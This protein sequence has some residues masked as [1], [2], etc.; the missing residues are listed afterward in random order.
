M[1]TKKS[2]NKTSVSQVTG[3]L[4]D[5]SEVCDDGNAKTSQQWTKSEEEAGYKKV[6]DISNEILN[7]G[8]LGDNSK[9]GMDALSFPN[10]VP[11]GFIRKIWKVMQKKVFSVN[12]VS[13]RENNDN[14]VASNTNFSCYH[15]DESF[16]SDLERAK[17]I[18]DDH[19]GKLCY[20]TPEDF[21]DRLKPNKR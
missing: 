11:K 19:P 6:L 3:I 14:P 10:N 15:C 12:E 5:V 7:Q 18:I 1:A 16:V 13:D 21:N 9:D 4:S 8:D 2:D 20:P 17:H